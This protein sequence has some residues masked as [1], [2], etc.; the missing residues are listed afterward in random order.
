MSH[1]I[2]P[3]PLGNAARGIAGSRVRV[4]TGVDVSQLLRKLGG[5]S[6]AGLQIYLLKIAFK[7]IRTEQ[8]S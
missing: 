1:I 6:S 3:D 5:A 4:S 2:G 8:P 7:Y